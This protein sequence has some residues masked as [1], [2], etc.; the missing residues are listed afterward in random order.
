LCELALRRQSNAMLPM[1]ESL[2]EPAIG[3]GDLID[4]IG[5]LLH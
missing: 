2:E 1:G 3:P 4:T 5:Q